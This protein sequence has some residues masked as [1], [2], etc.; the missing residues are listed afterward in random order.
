[1]AVGWISQPGLL[2]RKQELPHNDDRSN[3]KAAN[4]LE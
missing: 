4:V 2:T 1:M 3:M